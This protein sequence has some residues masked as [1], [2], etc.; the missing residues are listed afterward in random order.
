M[1]KYN[2]SKCEKL[3]KTK[4]LQ[5]PCNSKIQQVCQI[6]KLQN[7]LL[8]FMSRIL[9]TMIQEMGSHGFG[10]LHPC[11]FAGYSLPPDCF[12]GL[13][14]SVCSFS[15]HMVQAVSESTILGSGGWWPS[16][17]SSTRQCPSRDCVCGFQP[18]I[19]L[20]HCPSR[21]SP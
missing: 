17:H 16:P 3:A 2:H 8:D 4:G 5:N 15:R 9:V 20:P 1:G 19:F 6:L 12:Q 21:G 14:L 11:G 13:V 18:Y 7:D 10:K